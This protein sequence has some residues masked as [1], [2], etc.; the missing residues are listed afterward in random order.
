[1]QSHH[2]KLLVDVF[3]TDMHRVVVDQSKKLGSN[4]SNEFNVD[5]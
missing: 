5:V 2:W 4:P 3:A 1:M